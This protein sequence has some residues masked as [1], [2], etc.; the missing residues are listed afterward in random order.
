MHAF[1]IVYEYYIYC[2]NTKFYYYDKWM[3]GIFNIN[4]HRFPLNNNNIKIKWL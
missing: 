1:V 4:K 2:I 3:R